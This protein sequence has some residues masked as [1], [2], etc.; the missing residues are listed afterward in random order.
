MTLRV[1]EENK[2]IKVQ[3]SDKGIGI[4]KEDLERVLEPF[5]AIEKP[6]Y[7]KGTGLGLSII[8]DHLL[9]AFTEHSARA[10]KG[11]RSSQLC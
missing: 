11:F 1:E 6:T 2:S 7:V 10:E 9:M 4:R 5:S 3:V 8:V